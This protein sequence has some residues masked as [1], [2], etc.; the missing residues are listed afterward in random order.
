MRHPAYQECWCWCTY[1]RQNI[2]IWDILLWDSWLSTMNSIW[3]PPQSLV[4]TQLRELR[5]DAGIT[6]VQ[7]AQK[8]GK[9][10]SYVSKAESG[11]RRL[12]F[13]EVRAYCRAC[14]QSF[15]AFVGALEPQIEALSVA[16]PSQE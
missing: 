14:G 15:P 3:T 9:P 5:I 16:K 13:L 6:Q 8:L 10:Q 2:L 1:D 11:E 12:D 7:L 4:R